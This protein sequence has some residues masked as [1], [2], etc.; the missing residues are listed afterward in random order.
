MATKTPRVALDTGVL[1]R[2][3]LGSD[4]QAQQL[5]RSWQA[6]QCRPLIA[7]EGAQVLIKA[8]GYPKFGLDVAQQRELL[9]DFLPYAE[10]VKTNVAARMGGSAQSGQ[11]APVLKL[12][13]GAGADVLVSDCP[14]VHSVFEK[15]KRGDCQL[16]GSAEFL[17]AL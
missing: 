11:L 13:L 3:L 16:Q 2:A 15:S 9:A 8:L 7:A 14:R 1:L 17:A 10:V 4:A 12:A 5:R 6:G